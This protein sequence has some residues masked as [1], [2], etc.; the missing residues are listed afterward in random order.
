MFLLTLE[1]KLVELEAVQWC[2][3]WKMLPVEVNTAL[4][5]EEEQL[6]VFLVAKNK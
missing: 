3:H 6:A 1:A 5:V 2:L 4:P